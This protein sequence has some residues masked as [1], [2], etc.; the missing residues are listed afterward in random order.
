MIVN[1]GLRST[2]VF[3]LK[4]A[5]YDMTLGFVCVI[6]QNVSLIVYKLFID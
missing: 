1:S 4:L 3:K 2:L 5:N 6:R